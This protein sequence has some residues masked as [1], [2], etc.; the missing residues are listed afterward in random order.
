[1]LYREAVNKLCQR[2]LSNTFNAVYLQP[3]DKAGAPA[4]FKDLY[5]CLT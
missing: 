5:S 4:L 2:E 3:L 1:M